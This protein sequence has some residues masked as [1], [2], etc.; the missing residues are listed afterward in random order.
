MKNNTSTSNAEGMSS[1]GERKDNDNFSKITNQ[2]T[3][4]GAIES[5]FL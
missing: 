1:P 3:S 5:V 4:A 2:K